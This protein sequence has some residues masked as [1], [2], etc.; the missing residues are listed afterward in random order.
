MWIL[1][2]TI[3]ILVALLSQLPKSHGQENVCTAAA[4]ANCGTFPCVQTGEMFA[5]LC[6]DFTLKPNA[7]ACTGTAVTTTT[8]P[9]IVIPDQCANAN[10][11]VGST[12]MP[13]NQNPPLYVCLCANNVI[14]NPDCPTT[15]LANNPCLNTP[16]SNGAT[17]VVNRLTNQAVCVCPK[18]TYGPNCGYTCRPACDPSW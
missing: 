2:S 18:N 10:C 6:P 8:Q 17:C 7:A 1:K 14:A 3:F 12:C 15:P 16:C 13:A 11:P 5:C 4:V 9:P